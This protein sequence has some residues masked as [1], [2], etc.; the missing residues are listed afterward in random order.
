MADLERLP[1]PAAGLLKVTAIDRAHQPG[2]LF[3]GLIRGF[4]LKE[5][6][7]ACSAAWD[8]SCII[9][10]G[11]SDADMAAAVN[12]IAALRGGAVVVHD[13]AVLAELPLP[14]FGLI[15]EWPLDRLAQAIG[16]INQ[17]AAGLGVTFPDPFLSLVTLT[18]AA[19]PH[20]RICE[21]GLVNLRTGRTLALHVQEN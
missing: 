19:I 2:R 18:G 5:G 8:T 7:M 4:G 16:Q 21:E 14:V 3:T 10:V 1:D 6:A 9:V 17:R 11:A 20:L 15:S 12:R 13:G